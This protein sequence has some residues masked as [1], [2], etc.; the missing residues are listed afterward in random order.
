MSPAVVQ[1][2]WPLRVLVSE[3]TSAVSHGYP[4]GRL[5]RWTA[6]PGLVP[7]CVAPPTAC[8]ARPTCVMDRVWRLHHRPGI[9]VFQCGSGPS[10]RQ[11][12][13]AVHGFEQ[14]FASYIEQVLPRLAG[15]WATGAMAL[16]VMPNYA[17][18]LWAPPTLATIVA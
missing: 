3:V 8:L 11:T 16:V 10:Y 12:P 2:K 13:A 17:R 6:D 14:E 5:G 1:D 9:A 18:R 7:S 4:V 15:G